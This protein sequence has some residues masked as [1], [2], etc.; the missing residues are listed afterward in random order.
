MKTKGLL[1]GAVGALAVGLVAGLIWSQV[2]GRSSASSGSL[3]STATSAY[4]TATGST[5]AEVF[6]TI[7]AAQT[8]VPFTIV[9]PAAVPAGF[10]L[11][12]AS[13]LAGHGGSVQLD[14]SNGDPS[15]P[16]MISEQPNDVFLPG[17]VLTTAKVGALSVQEAT[18]QQP[19][20][21]QETVLL[22]HS[23]QLSVL[24]QARN[25][26]IATLESL[27]ASIH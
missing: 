6:S 10:H 8:H 21:L 7:I 9:A 12:A 22:F 1:V 11:S 24:I 16:L 25:V 19:G 26:P 17:L 13:Y 23:G 3:K 20:G 18:V 5:Q 15:M 27:A 2:P 14:Y 4:V